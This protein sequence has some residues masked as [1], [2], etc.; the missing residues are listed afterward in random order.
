MAYDQLSVYGNFSGSTDHVPLRV[1]AS[2]DEVFTNYGNL[3]CNRL[4]S[5]TLPSGKRVYTIRGVLPRN[6]DP[7]SIL[8]FIAPK[9]GAKMYKSTDDA[10]RQTANLGVIQAKDGEFEFSIEYPA[11]YREL[12]QDGFG[13]V[14]TPMV[15]IHCCSENQTFNVYL[16][17]ENE[18]FG[19][20][21]LSRNEQWFMICFL[22]FIG[23]YLINRRRIAKQLVSS[24]A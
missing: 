18:G 4:R 16:H 11:A 3:S 2:W 22:L 9:P 21:G 8:M 15:K 1:D 24:Q 5:N 23:W 19:L 14:H 13:R 20:A 10:Y 12:M 6:Y 7:N 17:H